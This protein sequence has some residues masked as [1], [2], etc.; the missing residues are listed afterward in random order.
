ME[1]LQA[2][3]PTNTTIQAAA[4]Y[5]KLQNLRICSSHSDVHKEAVLLGHEV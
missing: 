4:V 2:T 3:L 1:N 5:Q